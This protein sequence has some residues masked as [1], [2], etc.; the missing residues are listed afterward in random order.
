[1]GKHGGEEPTH[2][3]VEKPKPS[4]DGARPDDPGK[5]EKPEEK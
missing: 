1:M 4:S 2:K 5:H 3:P